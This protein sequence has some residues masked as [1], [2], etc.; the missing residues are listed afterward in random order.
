MFEPEKTSD[1]KLLENVGK[2]LLSDGFQAAL[3]D[4]M[5]IENLKESYENLTAKEIMN[6]VKDFLAQDPSQVNYEIF[7]KFLFYYPVS[8]CKREVSPLLRRFIGL[9]YRLGKH[10]PD[11]ESSLDYKISY[12][13]LSEI[14]CRSKATIS[15]CINKTESEWKQFK[16]EVDV[17]IER[18][19]YA[20]TEAKRQLIEEAKL[21][22]TENKTEGT[23]I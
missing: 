13:D 17:E 10:E 19:N 2:R 12:E 18:D 14:F 9:Y 3:C 8:I 1:Q 5:L 15:D 23:D 11:E 4:E 21:K 22:L 6:K 7:L 16:Q 20:I